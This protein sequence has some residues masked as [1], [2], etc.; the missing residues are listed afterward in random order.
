M[1]NEWPINSKD[2]GYFAIK[3]GINECGIECRCGI[4]DP[5]IKRPIDVNR[6]ITM[7]TNY[8]M[9]RSNLDGMLA[10]KRIFADYL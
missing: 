5:K 4:S 2:K 6:F 10:T 7:Y 8:D 3:M 9:F 1:G